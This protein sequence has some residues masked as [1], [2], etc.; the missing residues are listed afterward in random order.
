MD[1][2]RFVKKK[3]ILILCLVAGLILL[4]VMAEQ[5]KET[6]I[7]LPTGEITITY[8]LGEGEKSIV[9]KDETEIAL[10]NE[11][12]SGWNVSMYR[13]ELRDTH[14][15]IEVRFETG[16]I[17]RIARDENYGWIEGDRKYGYCF[18]EK[19]LDWVREKT[20]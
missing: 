20:E 19:F 7:T 1:M 18:P 4:A 8:D 15:E 12:L 11:Y 2:E 13:H 16:D 5:K 10:V 9:I 6:K 3:Y 14:C 17:L